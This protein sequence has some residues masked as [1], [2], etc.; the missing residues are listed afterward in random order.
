MRAF[1]V[2]S[3]ASALISLPAAAAVDPAL[4]ALVAPDARIVT[5]IQVDQSKASKFGQFVLS[6]ITDNADLKKFT[7]DSGFDPRRDLKEIV[8][9]TS[10]LDGAGSLVIGRGAFQKERLLGAARTAGGVSSIHN[11]IEMVS[12]NDIGSLSTLAFLDSSTALVGDQASVKAAIDRRSSGATGLSAAMATKAREIGAVNDAWFVTLA[13]LSEFLGSR[14]AD[15]NLGAAMQGNLLQ[16]VQQA[17]GGV[18][19]GASEVGIG[20]EAVTRSDKD[21]SALADV[22]RFF[23]S[24]LQSNQT[25]SDP[26]T[27]KAASL[28]EKMKL[29]TQAN[30]MKLSL[31]IPEADME[32]MFLSGPRVH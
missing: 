10:G 27:V 25:S 20:F 9:A 32:R 5:G 8:V 29:S 2:L 28:A 14:M 22:L 24:M 13:P 16:A 30:I 23:A 6:Q 18:K 3:I 12:A 11:G 21:A 19:F 17:S 26:K 1:A 7:L 31:S 4:L 15:A